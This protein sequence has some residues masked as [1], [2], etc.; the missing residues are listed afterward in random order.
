[1]DY[2]WEELAKEVGVTSVALRKW[3]QR[4]GITKYTKVDA[5]V[6]DDIRNFIRHHKQPNWGYRALRA[7]WVVETQLVVSERVFAKIV[8]EEDPEGV[9]RL[10]NCV[11]IA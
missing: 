8:A 4:K 2:S 6:E 7:K 11:P 5:N 1:M 3:A 10:F 9:L